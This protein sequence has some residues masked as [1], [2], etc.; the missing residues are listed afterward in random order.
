[1]NVLL[2]GEESAGIQMLRSLAQSSHRVVAVLASPSRQ[3][4]GGATVWSAAQNMGYPTWPAKLV[5]EASFADPVRAQAVDLILNVHSL[6]IIHKDVL[7]ATRI[8]AF[9]MHPGPLPRYAGLNAVSWALYR[10][11]R[12]HGVTIHKMAAE[13]DAGP[14]AYQALFPI[15]EHDSALMLSAKCVKAGVALMTQLLEIAACNPDTIPQIHQNLTKREYFGAEIPEDGR[16]SWSRPAKEVVNFVRAGDYFPFRSPWG[17]PRAR[18]GDS[19]IGIVKASCTGQPADLVAPG[20]IGQIDG[21]GV[22]VACADEWVVVSKLRLND[23]YV[24]ATTVLKP[25][26]QLDDGSCRQ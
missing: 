8:G 2:V 17:H 1:M 22:Y 7:A 9:N 5:R 3:A 18:M 12:T 16:L 20:T 14:I 25:E 4:N 24:D 6:H 13:V 26:E 11:E 19:D 23:K 15:E 21:P 10:G